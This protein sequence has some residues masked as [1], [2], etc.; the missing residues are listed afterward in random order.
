MAESL[1]VPIKITA[2]EKRKIRFSVCKLTYSTTLHTLPII[3]KGKEIKSWDELW[4]LKAYLEEEEASLSGQVVS[5][6]NLLYDPYAQAE[7]TRNTYRTKKINPKFSKNKSL[8]PTVG[9]INH[10]PRTVINLI[11]VILFLQ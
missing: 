6:A 1:G 9:N 10:P 11:H 7:C 3:S 5:Y 2:G 4:L 8:N